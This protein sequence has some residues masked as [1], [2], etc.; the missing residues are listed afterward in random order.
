[1]ASGLSIE[2]LRHSLS[3]AEAIRRDPFGLLKEISVRVAV[4]EPEDAQELVL[5]ALDKRELFNGY[6]E[7]LDSLVRRVG[8]YPYLDPSSLGVSDLL[9]Y[10]F[11]RPKSLGEDVVFHEVQARVYQDLLAGRS[12]ILSAPTSFGKSLI[13]DALIA[14]GKYRNVVIVVPT[15]ALIDETRRR[16]S[17]FR[18]DFRIIT[19]I[20][21]RL[22]DRNVLVLTQER[23]V[24]F[25]QLPPVDLFI[26]DEFYKLSPSLD[27]ER[28]TILNQA[29]YRLFKTGAQFYLLGPDIRELPPSLPERLNCQFFRTDYATVVSEAQRVHA[30][31]ER[32]ELS[33]LCRDLDGSTLIY[34]RSP[35]RVRDVVG[36]LLEDE[37]SGEPVGVEMAVDWM[38][39]EY[40]PAW[41]AARALARGIAVHHG[42]MPR[43]L[44]QYMVRCF[45]EA[46][47][48][49]LVCT[50]TLIEGVNTKAKNVIV[51][52]NMIAR[53]KY[54]Y[55]TF[56]N[57]R[58][59][60]GRMFQHFIGRVFLFHE[61]PQKELPFVDVPVITQGE[62]TSTS[63]LVQIDDEDLLKRSRQRLRGILQQTLL[64]IAVIR[65]NAGI[66]PDQQIALAEEIRDNLRD[67]APRLR[68]HGPPI[69]EQLRFACKLI[70]EHLKSTNQG[71]AGVK[72]ADQLAF[73]V[74]RFRSNPEISALIRL[75]LEGRGQPTPDEAV[76]SVLDFLRQWASFDFPRFLLA[77]HRIQHS[78]LTSLGATSGDYTVFAAMVESLFMP[79][80]LAALDEYGI[81]LQTARKLAEVLLPEGD[82]DS[83][84]ERLR[85]IDA[86]SLT[87]LH[88]FE[89]E[90]IADAQK[91]L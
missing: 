76:E 40:H 34:C 8:L 66:D 16:L 45:N 51:F 17:R 44:S 22:G 48:K 55:F 7:V 6:G 35:K 72:S 38:A 58:G 41:L 31:D 79:A 71:R 1:M 56:N 49:L 36:W 14:S 15:I 3:D 24:A 26:V 81:P 28:S 21:Q 37:V 30:K 50:S 85:Q 84:L 75:E 4:D 91:Y 32:A 68:W 39:R 87:Q 60:S 61:P 20:T 83:V 82:L 25:R 74:N 13:I 12:V 78:V 77:L 46:R 33:R 64:D 2:A 86:D 52:D 88:P 43:A 57:I 19:H 23:V 80:P 11:H 9:A 89:R 18:S 70:W 27:E 73:K 65:E 54:D 62:R 67:Y 59:R 69:Y 42:R 53:R 90:L 47:T 29:F 63:L 10:E 5:R